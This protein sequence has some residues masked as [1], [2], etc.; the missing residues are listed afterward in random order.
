MPLTQRRSLHFFA[1][2]R[3]SIALLLTACSYTNS[4]ALSEA[5]LDAE[6]IN[7]SISFKTVSEL[8]LQA[9]WVTCHAK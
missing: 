7:A 1:N 4:K 2:I 8:V 5:P 9:N 3:S 6:L